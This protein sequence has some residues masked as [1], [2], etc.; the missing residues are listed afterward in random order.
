MMLYPVVFDDS[1]NFILEKVNFFLHDADPRS[2][3]R[4]W[5]AASTTIL[6]NPFHDNAGTHHLGRW[7]SSSTST[8]N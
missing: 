2:F 7:S 3:R 4:C 1:G 8:M 5:Y 6:L